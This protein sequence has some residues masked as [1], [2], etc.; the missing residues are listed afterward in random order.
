MESAAT[1]EELFGTWRLVSWKRELL[2]TG[3]TVEAF[4]KAPRGFLNYGRDGH[5]FFIMAKETR[6]TPADLARLTDHERTEL[7][8]TMVAYAGTFAFDGKTA[9][10]HVEISWNEIWTGTAQI[11]HLK[12]EGPRLIMSTDPQRG[13]DGK[14]VVGVFTWEKL[15]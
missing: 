10:H 11:R 3:E 15:T 4:G 2:D 1:L 5:V 9:T 12:F 6:E 14:R 8:N 7:Y 13:F